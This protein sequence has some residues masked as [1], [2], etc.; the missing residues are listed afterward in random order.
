MRELISQGIDDLNLALVQTAV[1]G[2][3]YKR[4]ERAEVDEMAAASADKHPKFGVLAD[5]VYEELATP[6][7]GVTTLEFRHGVEETLAVV[8]QALSEYVDLAAMKRQFP[9]GLNIPTAVGDIR[10]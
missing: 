7:D 5:I 3:V 10:L 8:E 1:E 4:R 6:M 9:Q 2:A